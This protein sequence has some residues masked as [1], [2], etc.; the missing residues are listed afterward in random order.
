MAIAQILDLCWR[1]RYKLTPSFDMP[2]KSWTPTNGNLCIR[3]ILL[4][5]NFDV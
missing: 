1:I 4:R 3:N 2:P 5:R